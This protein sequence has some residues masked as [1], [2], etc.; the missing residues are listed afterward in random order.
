MTGFLAR[1]IIGM[2]GCILIGIGSLVYP[3][4][5]YAISRNREYLSDLGAVQL[6]KDHEAMI[7]ALKK[8][9]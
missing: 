3:L 9:K 2:A 4:I 5:K 8:I 1:L 7:S 6:T